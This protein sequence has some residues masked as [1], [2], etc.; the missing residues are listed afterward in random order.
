MNRALR[1]ATMLCVVACSPKTGTTGPSDLTSLLAQT[2]PGV[3]L[4]V[5]ELPNGKLGYGSGVLLDDRRVLTNLH[6]ATGGNGSF[7]FTH[8]PERES[9]TTL[10]GG[11][12][13]YVREYGNEAVPTRLMRADPINDLALVELQVPVEDVTPLSF[14]DTPPIPGETVTA[15]GHPQGNVW[16]F[17][18]GVVS[19]VHR[20][21]IQHDA[22]INPGNSGGPL[23]DEQGQVVGI[24]TFRLQAG[25]APIGIG[26]ARPLEVLE[27]LIASTPWEG[28][29]LSTPEASY[30]SQLRGVELG[31][32]EAVDAM[33]VDG[34]IQLMT[35]IQ[36]ELNE[37]M[38]D[39]L[40]ALFGPKLDRESARARLNQMPLIT[41]DQLRSHLKAQ[42][43][44]PGSDTVS[45]L[46]AN[47]ERLMSSDV[48]SK[49]TE[50]AVLQD[51]YASVPDY[52]PAAFEACG[53]KLPH[54]S[55]DQQME[56]LKLGVRVEHTAPGRTENEAWVVSS[57]FNHD[58][59]TWRCGCLMVREN[60]AWLSVALPSAE[61]VAARPDGVPAPAQDQAIVRDATLESAIVMMRQT[62]R[63][64]INVEPTSDPAPAP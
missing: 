7:A 31:R 27:P 52:D 51:W 24:N 28:L 34:F 2:F 43:Q 59:S 40:Q 57:G 54:K 15:L 32:P 17:S 23:L 4:L 64:F 8:D 47:L 18:R 41:E 19:A 16:S 56:M 25:A 55:K 22:A 37:V 1:L 58:G 33:V 36:P 14:R 3:V 53:I 30:R 11:I 12:L 46:I 29:D 20:G 49:N 13:R 62:I 10:D 6:V 38:L 42:L 9:Y 61:A 26:Y 50:I 21:A 48:R 60:G 5:R 45:S 35:D 39:E 44:G 63:A